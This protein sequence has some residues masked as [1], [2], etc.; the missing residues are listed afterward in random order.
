MPY[1]IL[2]IEDE[3][4]IA[5]QI[6]NYLESE[7]FIV[8]GPTDDYKTSI[9]VI[10]DQLP[11][12]IIADIRLHDDIEGGIKISEFVYKNYF[13][14]VI[15]LSAFSDNVTRIKAKSTN[16]NTFLI[17]PKPLDK[18]QLLTTIQMALPT[19]KNENKCKA[20]LLQGKEID[21][22]QISLESE[23]TILSEK[24]TMKIH[25]EDI[26]YVEAFNHY[27]KNTVL[28]HF[29]S[30]NTCFLVRSEIGE[31]QKKLPSI[32]IRVHKSFL[33]NM[34]KVTGQKFPHFIKQH[35]VQIPIGDKYLPLVESYLGKEI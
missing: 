24:I 23:S 4:L 29:H 28:L 10:S 34:E 3:Y 5:N 7:G 27:F 13:I 16:P 12:L 11:D 6:K 26:T 33:V 19:K 8:L 17:K 31:I 9:N 20:I 2:I 25:T 30:T 14:P 15:F 18:K 35:H 21:V 22:R 32:F 1:K